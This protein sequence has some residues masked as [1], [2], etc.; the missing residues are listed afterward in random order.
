MRRATAR[1]F[2]QPTSPKSPEPPTEN[3][4]NS[5]SKKNHV[6]LVKK[7]IELQLPD[8]PSKMP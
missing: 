7:I 5:W 6:I 4:Q 1:H 3:T 8:M 2:F